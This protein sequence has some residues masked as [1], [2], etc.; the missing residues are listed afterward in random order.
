MTEIAVDLGFDHLGRF[1]GHYR[2]LYRETPSTTLQHHFPH[3]G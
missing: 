2:G 1:A 3:A